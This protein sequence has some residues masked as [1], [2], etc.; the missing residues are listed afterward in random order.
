MADETFAIALAAELGGALLYWGYIEGEDF[1]WARLSVE[2][3]AATEAKHLLVRA[4]GNCPEH[5][6]RA[7]IKLWRNPPP[8][9]SFRRGINGLIPPIWIDRINAQ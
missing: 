2:E 9:H 8:G 3:T 1:S 7:A 6:V 4:W 5:V